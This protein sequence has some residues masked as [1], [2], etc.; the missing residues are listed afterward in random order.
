MRIRLISFLG[1]VISEEEATKNINLSPE[2]TC[3]LLL[4]VFH[5]YLASVVF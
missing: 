3:Y 5:S 2:I 4:Y 1:Y